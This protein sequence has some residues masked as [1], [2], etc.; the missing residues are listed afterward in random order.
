MK[1][2]TLLL[3][4]LLFCQLSIKSQA[5]NWV[6]LTQT[7]NF[8]VFSMAAYNGSMVAVGLFTNAGGT[9][10]NH[11]AAWNGSTWTAFGQGIRSSVST[12]AKVLVFNNEVYVAGRF[13]SA[14]VVASKNIAKWNGSNWVSMAAS[15]NN[16]I[17][18]LATYN[19]EIYAAGSFTTING[20][21]ASHIAKWNGTAWQAVGAGLQGTNVNDLYVYQN[22]LY[23]VGPID[24]AAH[25]ACNHIA[26]WNGSAWNTVS[27]GVPSGNG[28]L[29]LYE[30]QSKLLIGANTTSL[31][32]EIHQWDGTNVSL[33]SQQIGAL[34]YG[35]FLAFNNK[36]YN[37]AIPLV[38]NTS[39]LLWDSVG[40]KIYPVNTFCEYNSELYCAGAFTTT[41]GSNGNYIAKMGFPT[42]IKNNTDENFAM[43]IFPNPTNDKVQMDFENKTLI[44]K[45]TLSNCLGQLVYVLNNP[46]SKQEID[47]SSFPSGIY[48]LKAESKERQSFFKII[49]E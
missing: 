1:K 25:I 3:I 36:L 30:W 28:G 44:N 2:I 17:W 12:V 7:V 10:V 13:D 29:G 41:N 46:I 40:T 18:C 34:C 8:S 43:N 15:C 32:A 19:N 11:V 38:W 31:G 45:V 48:F 24:S 16:I 14:G 27:T 37:G 9:Q 20:V 26:R 23:A 42:G 22:E 39:T 47:M 35:N 4:L 33:F 21:N 49:K 5:M 6:P